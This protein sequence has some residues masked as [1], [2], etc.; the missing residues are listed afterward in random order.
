MPAFLDDA[1]L[2]VRANSIFRQG[3]SGPPYPD[4]LVASVTDANSSARDA[5]ISGL[6]LRGY[7]LAAIL[8][9]QALPAFHAD[10]AMYFTS[11]RDKLDVGQST[12][13][14]GTVKALD[15]REELKSLLLTDVD[16]KLILPTVLPRSSAVGHGE[17]KSTTS[18]LYD[19]CTR[20]LRKW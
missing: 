12:R 1:A 5:I 7:D 17:I 2:L 20:A 18:R 4:W 11:L 14:F 6:S 9:W 8:R 3:E 15:R 13:D 16:G 19:P 10:L